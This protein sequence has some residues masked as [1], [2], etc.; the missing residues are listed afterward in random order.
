MITGEEILESFDIEPSKIIGD[1]KTEIKDAILD[2]KIENDPIQ[3]KELMFV[4][5]ER[6]KLR[7][8]K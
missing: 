3:A 1:I 2:G 5:G 6:K 7:R 8:R 4:I